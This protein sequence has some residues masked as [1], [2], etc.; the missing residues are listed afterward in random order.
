[1][2]AGIEIDGVRLN[3]RFFHVN[4]HVREVAERRHAAHV[5]AHLLLHLLRL[6]KRNFLAAGCFGD[7]LPVHTLIARQHHH[8]HVP[9]FSV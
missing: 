2:H 5:T 7:L 8:D 9:L 3:Q 6:G 1:M 4:G